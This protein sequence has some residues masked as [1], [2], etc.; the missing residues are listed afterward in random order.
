MTRVPVRHS[1]ARWGIP[2]CPQTIGRANKSSRV[3]HAEKGPF[4][5]TAWPRH[6]RLHP[7]ATI[8]TAPRHVP[9]GRDAFGPAVAL[10]I[11][12][13]RHRVVSGNR[14]AGTIADRGNTCRI[15][16]KRLTSP[17]CPRRDAGANP[18]GH[19][20]VRARA[21]WPAWASTCR[22]AARRLRPVPAC[23]HRDAAGRAVRVWGPSPAWMACR[24][25]CPTSG[26]PCTQ[27]I[28]VGPDIAPAGKKITDSIR[29]RPESL[30][31]ASG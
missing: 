12:R 21:T 9:A 17:P 31:G 22:I 2:T 15:G 6:R 10:S 24:C 11:I 20:T 19:A 14:V 1:E 26:R 28:E 4:F 5:E 30:A 25:C 16:V 27:N 8:P 13:S 18:S 23:P 29:P 3:A 7:R